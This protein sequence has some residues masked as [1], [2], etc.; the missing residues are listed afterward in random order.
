MT[1]LQ[2]ELVMEVDTLDAETALRDRRIVKLRS[3][4]VGDAKLCYLLIHSSSNCYH[5]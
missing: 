1:T 4:E 2:D 5:Q 3:V